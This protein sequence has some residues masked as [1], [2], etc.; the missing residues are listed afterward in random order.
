MHVFNQFV[1]TLEENWDDFINSVI[2]N[3]LVVT[4]TCLFYCIYKMYLNI[5]HKTVT[6]CLMI[7]IDNSENMFVWQTFRV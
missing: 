5:L 7:V 1:T 3:L 2:L 6:V 4:Y